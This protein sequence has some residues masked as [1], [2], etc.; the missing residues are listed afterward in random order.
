VIQAKTPSSNSQ[1]GREAELA[2]IILNFRTPKLVA[3]CLDT[4]RDQVDPQVAVLIVDNASGDGSA[5]EIRAFIAE[6]GYA[7][8]RVVESPVNGGFAA[9]NNVGIRAI[10]AG[11]YLLLNSDTLIRPGAIG[12][13]R[14]ALSTYSN[15]G[16]IV[17]RTE[18][19]NG[20]FDRNAFVTPRPISE[21]VRGAKLGVLSRLLRRFDVVA[22]VP[23]TSFEP[24]W[25]GFCAVVVRREVIDRVGLLDEQFFMYY[26]DI[27]YCMRV[28]AGG[29]AI[30]YCPEARV[31]HLLG[32]SSGLTSKNGV[33]KR[34]ARY[35]YEARA[36]F[37]AKH[38]G[39][40]GLFAANVAFDAGY[41]I[42]RARGLATK[43]S[44]GHRERE[45]VDVWIN[46]LAP[47]RPYTH[48]GG[49]N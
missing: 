12:A 18:N 8:A 33:E 24:E 27:D 49:R 20:E 4:L 10:D 3:D 25:V 1:A 5:D 6:R 40:P 15:A 17:P 9:G 35:M 22:D 2:V 48:P 23:T 42:A 29:F 16:L 44:F 19:I 41:A 37:F 36:R 11:A 7:F 13:L 43:R 30:R 26:E 47:F 38:Y 21:L 34:A 28:R 39:V 46:A 14:E 32:A 31:V 45:P